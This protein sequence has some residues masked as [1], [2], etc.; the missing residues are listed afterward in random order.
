MGNPTELL[1]GAS[2]RGNPIMF[3]RRLLPRKAPHNDP[4]GM[5]AATSSMSRLENGESKNGGRLENRPHFKLRR[6]K[7]GGSSERP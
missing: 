3:P 1:R 5:I 7:S 4:I 6:I 2:C